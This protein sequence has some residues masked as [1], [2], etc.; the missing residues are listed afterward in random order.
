M[1]WGKKL[2]QVD[3]DEKLLYWVLLCAIAPSEILPVDYFISKFLKEGGGGGGDPGWEIEHRSTPDGRGLYYVWGDSDISGIEPADKEYPSELVY[4]FLK[5]SLLEF[6][7]AY[8]ERGG[9]VDE[10]ISKYKL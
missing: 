5:R 2:F 6:A 4:E 10:V 8:P 1:S 7:E 9:E 3:Q